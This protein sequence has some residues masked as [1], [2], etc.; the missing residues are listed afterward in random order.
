MVIVVTLIEFQRRSCAAFW[1]SINVTTIRPR[2]LARLR[3]AVKFAANVYQG[4]R[5][6]HSLT[7]GYHSMHA[8]GVQYATYLD[9]IH[10]MQSARLSRIAS[11][12]RC[13]RRPCPGSTHSKR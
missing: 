11:G 10:W 9:S 6:F 3:R 7:P 1:N 12:A 4:L 2:I 8:S 5:S 13:A